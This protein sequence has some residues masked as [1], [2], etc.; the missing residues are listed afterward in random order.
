[1]EYESL[2]SR[3]IN[4]QPSPSSRRRST[5]RRRGRSSIS[6]QAR[7]LN[8]SSSRATSTPKPTRRS[9]Y[10]STQ[11]SIIDLSSM[12]IND[13]NNNDLV[14]LNLPLPPSGPS[15]HSPMAVGSLPFDFSPDDE[16]HRKSNIDSSTR[17]GKMN[18]KNVL[19]QFTL[20]ADGR[21][22]CNNC[23]QVTFIFCVE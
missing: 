18:K 1:M 19:S 15:H 23:H 21:Y 2:P 13:R 17:S 12:A 6:I 16:Q 20:R 11:S 14:P 4:A 5:S 10:L 3:S 22:E 7:G 9:S 8:R